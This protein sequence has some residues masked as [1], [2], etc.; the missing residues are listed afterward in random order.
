M[1]YGREW[2][3]L[4]FKTL[5]KN[6]TIHKTHITHPHLSRLC[7]N[8]QQKFHFFVFTIFSSVS[9][10]HTNRNDE[11]A[12]GTGVLMYCEWKN[13]TQNFNRNNRVYCSFSAIIMMFF[14]LAL[15]SSK[16]S[17]KHRSIGWQS[18]RGRL[19]SIK[20][21][22]PSYVQQQD[23][24]MASSGTGQKQLCIHTHQCCKYAMVKI[25]LQ[26]SFFLC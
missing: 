21:S 26:K 14:F 22:G 12:K 6:I 3:W 11:A 1:L 9:S 20:C 25:W 18:L 24:S 4:I 16:Q 13:H 5:L 7:V 17:V 19:Y 8:V 15:R 23:G 2:Y 10:L